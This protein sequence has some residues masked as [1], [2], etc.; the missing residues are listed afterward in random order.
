MNAVIEELGS[1]EKPRQ[2]LGMSMVGQD[3]ERA[4]WYSLRWCSVPGGGFDAKTLRNFEDGHRGEDLMAERLR[5]VPK[6]KLL[7]IDPSTGRQFKFSDFGGH[8]Q[9]HIDGVVLGL[10]QAPKTWHCWE[11]KVSE[12]VAALEKAKGEVGE[13][14][15]LQKWNEVYFAQAQLYMHYADLDRSYLTV[16]S[17]GGRLPETSVRTNKQP[18]VVARLREKA[19]RVITAPEPLPRLSEDAA[20]WKCRGCS[21]RGTCHG[22]ALPAPSCRTCL[23]ATPSLDGADG[24]WL[25]ALA[26]PDAGPIPLDFQQRGC[27]RHLYVPALLSRWGAAEDA[28]ESEGWVQYRAADGL[29]FR[30]GPWAL[31][32][33]TSKELHGL[34][35]RAMRDEQLQAIRARYAAQ[36][37]ADD[38]GLPAIEE[39]A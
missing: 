24:D 34:N 1:R 22:D 31:D 17:P 36:F 23:H 25:C 21:F 37:T 11:N 33:F 9:G 30:N 18:E 16:Q 3:C 29:T 5:L 10:L 2:Y 4:S 35:P 32:T 13:K 38:G 19:Q 8:L 28:S 39:A 12:K 27:E 15:A 20:F 6:L 26:A 7:T 14:D